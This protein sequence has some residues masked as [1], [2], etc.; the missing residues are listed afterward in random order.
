M[1]TGHVRIKKAA[2]AVLLACILLAVLLLAEL[3]REAPE[4]PEIT[5]P[6]GMVLINITDQNVAASYHVDELGVYVLAVDENSQ[7]YCAGVRSGDRIVSI[8][9]TPIHST[10]DLEAVQWLFPPAS[11]VRMDFRPQAQDQ[12]FTASLLWSGDA[13]R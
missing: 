7:A 11:M 10:G 4:N 6:F 12:L 3:R 1:Q 13:G 8:N 2:A 5:S 9:G